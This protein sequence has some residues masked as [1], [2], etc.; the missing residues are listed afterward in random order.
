MFRSV[1][2]VQSDVTYPTPTGE[3]LHFLYVHQNALPL[4]LAVLWAPCK[5]KTE[6]ENQKFI[7]KMSA[8]LWGPWHCQDYFQGWTTRLTLTLFTNIVS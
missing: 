8:G 6:L 7:P 4:V 3:T 1:R 5:R 2:A